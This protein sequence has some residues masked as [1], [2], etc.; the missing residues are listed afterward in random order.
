[1]SNRSFDHLDDSFWK[2]VCVFKQVN[3][4]DINM[5]IELKIKSKHLSLESKV[6][7][8]EEK[9]LAKQITHLVKKHGKPAWDIVDAWKLCSQISSITQH[10]KRDV[11]NENRSTFLARAYL[12]GDAYSKVEHKRNPDKEH[13]FENTI[14]P[15][16]V[17]MV[18]KYK[19]FRTPIVTVDM[20][21][22]WSKL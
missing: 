4:R 6:I 2:L 22:E 1:M 8:H 7:R 9:K 21:M 15:R 12:E 3:Q 14:L 5:S 20:L 11:R 17:K 13:M 18:N 16:V 19:P 10:R